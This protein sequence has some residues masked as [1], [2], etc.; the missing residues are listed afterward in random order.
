MCF[1][2][3]V[4]LKL[5][6]PLVFSL[7]AE[8]HMGDESGTSQGVMVSFIEHFETDV[9]FESS[10]DFDL[11]SMTSFYGILWENVM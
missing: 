3:L 11:S 4:I 7:L 8:K 10:K 5:V 1:I 6:E 9:S 2:L